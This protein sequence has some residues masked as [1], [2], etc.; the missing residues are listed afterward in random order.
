MLGVR[1]GGRNKLVA[2]AA[3]IGRIYNASVLAQAYPASAAYHKR[4]DFRGNSLS[5]PVNFRSSRNRTS[6][7]QEASPHVHP[8]RVEKERPNFFLSLRV[9]DPVC[10]ALLS[11]LH[12]SRS[13]CLPARHRAGST[14]PRPDST[15]VRPASSYLYSKDAPYP[16]CLLAFL[17]RSVEKGAEDNGRCVRV[18]VSSCVCL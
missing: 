18:C 1:V 6:M 5:T 7:E 12:T 9:N 13:D 17:H 16:L 2:L 14:H 8:E 11:S 4:A 10:V 15:Q 3:F